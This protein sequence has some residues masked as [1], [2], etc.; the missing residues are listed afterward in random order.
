MSTALDTMYHIDVVLKYSA[1]FVSH[2]M[3]LNVATVPGTMISDW[4]KMIGITPALL[5]RS[6]MKVFCPSR[7]RPRPITLRGIWTGIR[8]AATVMATVP[9]TTRSEERRVGNG[10]RQRVCGVGDR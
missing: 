9:A 10:G 1:K 6:G 7:M 5:M 4:A 3:P 2:A 8:R